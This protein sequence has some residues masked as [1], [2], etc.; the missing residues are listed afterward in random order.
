MDM[1]GGVY[2]RRPE[3]RDREGSRAAQAA[4]RGGAAHPA[5]QGAAR[6]VRQTDGSTTTPSARRASCW[7]PNIARR[8]AR[9]RAQSIVLLKNEGKLL[10]LRRD[11]AAD[12]SPSSAR[13][14]R[15][16]SQLGSWRA[17]GKAEDVV[18]MLQGHH[19]PRRRPRSKWCPRRA[20][21]RATT[22]SSGIRRRGE[23]GA[24]RGRHRA[25]D[26]RGLRPLGRGAQPFGSRAAA[27]PAGAR[28]PRARHRQARGR[29]CSR[30][31]ARS[32]CRGSRKRRRRSSRPGCWAS[33]AGNAVA[34]VLFGAAFAGRPSARGLPARDRRGAVQ[35]RGQRR[36]A[37]PRIRISRRTR[38]AIT[39]CR[40]RRCF[41]SATACRTASS[42]T[43][44]SRRA[45][46]T[47]GPGERVDISITRGEHRRRG[48]RRGGA[49]LR[50][51]SGAH[52]S[53]GR[54]SSCAASSASSSARATR[55]RV[56]LQPDARAVRVLEPARP[57]ARRS[58]AASTSGSARRP[59][60][61]APS[62]SFEITQNTHRV[63]RRPRRCP[64][65]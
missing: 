57:V 23:A 15:R 21:I 6:P 45:C 60:T 41:P 62:G 51:R 54:C 47:I 24:A 10:P 40:S 59:R 13:S 37:A 2:A 53:R 25:R 4:R 16:P 12:A 55:K 7:P 27:E 5:R 31:A 50:A 61:C 48:E 29:A 26:R 1:V 64:R 42:A 43:A 65:E 63:R 9:S 19:A 18:T 20:P 56:T 8:R 33:R 49:A 3:G 52:R 35:L 11:E 22:T 28:A 58:R 46:G 44:I 36:P 32:R 17:Q 14:R 38:C 30:M 39:T 34:D